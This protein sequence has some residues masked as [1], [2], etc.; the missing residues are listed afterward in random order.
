MHFWG[1][2]KFKLGGP[3]SICTV[4]VHN[5]NYV[6]SISSINNVKNVKNVNNVNNVNMSTNPHPISPTNCGP[7]LLFGQCLFESAGAA[8][9][10]IHYKRLHSQCFPTW[11]DLMSI[12]FFWWVCDCTVRCEDYLLT[13]GDILILMQPCQ[14]FIILIL[15]Q[16][17]G[18]MSLH[19][20]CSLSSVFILV[21]L[22]IFQKESCEKNTQT[23]RNSKST[24]WHS[25][26]IEAIF[27]TVET[28]ISIQQYPLLNL[29][30][31]DAS[32]DL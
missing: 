23:W 15:M 26:K 25:L 27:F 19:P 1:D 8:K 21:Y 24:V 11:H 14:W 13:V 3:Q 31:T 28:F 4:G 29:L 7:Q 5:V 9:K 17:P 20:L 22:Q 18:L 30:F 6:N 2:H 32:I 10:N 12:V 16:S